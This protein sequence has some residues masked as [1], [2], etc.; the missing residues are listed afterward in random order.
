MSSTAPAAWGSPPTPV[1]PRWYIEHM[2]FAPLPNALCHRSPSGEPFEVVG[3]LTRF[4]EHRSRS[5]TSDE[6][7]ALVALAN[8]SK[9]NNHSGP[10]EELV[11]I[12][13][14]VDMLRL[15]GFPLRRRT[16]N[17]IRR[18]LNAK[19][20]Q[21]GQPVTVGQLL[22]LHS[23]GIR[24]L[25]DL[26]CIVEAALDTGLLHLA[27]AP[28]SSS[29]AA[30]TSSEEET[31]LPDSP[32]PLSVA[33]DSATVLLKRLLTAAS[34]INRARTLSDALSG[35][36][37]EL[38]TSLGMAEH[39]SGIAIADL[40]GEPALAQEVLSALHE[41]WGSLSP[42]EQ[43]I[44][45]RRLLTADP[46]TLEEVGQTAN[47]TRERIRQIEKSVESRL[48]H[49]S[50]TGPAAKCWVGM[51]AAVLR[52]EL[53][54]ITH[55]QDLEERVSATFPAQHNLEAP[56]GA[57]NEMARHLLQQE[58]DYSCADGVCLSSAARTVIGELKEQASSLADEIGLLKETALRDCLQD[59][60]W[61]QHWEA[62]LKQAG[63]HR[64]NN[65][66]ALRD[67][68]KAKAKAALLS[69]GRPATKEEIGE[70]SGL[71]PDRAGAQLSLLSGV[72]RADK[73]RWGLAEWVD[74]EYEGIPAEIIQRIN[75]DGGSTRL[76]RLLEEL[77]R[78]FEVSESSVEAYAKTAR[79]Q[80]QDGY[81]SLADP[82]L[83]RL[84]TLDDVIDGR[85]TDGLAY[86]SFKAEGRYFDGYSLSGLPA[87]I[88]KALGCEPD[89]RV[90]IPVASPD[91]CDPVSVRWPL[92]SLAGASLG[93]LSAP[94]T[95][96]G[97]REGDKV[98][99]V[100]DS[101]GN[102]S[103]HRDTPSPQDPLAA[104]PLEGDSLKSERAKDLLERMK[105]RRRGL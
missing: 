101:P 29:P 8:P 72:V 15:L 97:A 80:I 83:I 20:L 6:H 87:E 38:A 81:V 46:L 66:L 37:G 88:A 23:F 57:V 2:P 7:N 1:L 75:E 63:L 16:R 71:R 69:I 64:L 67:T 54:P 34:E 70:L 24:S 39:L 17:C 60:K 22:S 55:R 25:L 10:P 27:P 36:L 59:D 89:G 52:Q 103:F 53:G 12:P 99:F 31:A 3:N 33:W 44:L 62:L 78:M 100:L 104:T 58:L 45:N 18:A 98:L 85:T 74:D 41:L 9:A 14:E 56:N 79:F 68:S 91:G 96:L 77:P 32:D 76:N 92:T 65:H 11:V 73:K 40:T 86:W 82:S 26:M 47:L 4:W 94:L 5:L 105:S 35:D 93:Y 43:T 102:V 42:V 50:I 19:K 28:A 95:K 61:Q 13:G 48:N 49:P 84:R 90:R 21:V 30:P 51:L